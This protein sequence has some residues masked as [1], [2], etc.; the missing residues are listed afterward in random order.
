LF[1]I[2]ASVVLFDFFSW[3]LK[4]KKSE[5]NKAILKVEIFIKKS[6]SV[7]KVEVILTYSDLTENS[8][9]KLILQ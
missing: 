6:L 3:Q 8:I 9:L 7:A 1:A 5:K 2:A 4:A